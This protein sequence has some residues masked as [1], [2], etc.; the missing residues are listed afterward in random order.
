MTFPVEGA[1]GA[2]V[3]ERHVTIRS[4]APEIRIDFF[5]TETEWGDEKVTIKGNGFG[6]YCLQCSI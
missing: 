4:F 1:G 6:M 3:G 5:P 2:D